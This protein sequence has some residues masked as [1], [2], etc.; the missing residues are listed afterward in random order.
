MGSPK[1]YDTGRKFARGDTRRPMLR[2]SRF[3]IRDTRHASTNASRVAIRD[4][5]FT[6]HDS[7][8]TTREPMIH[9]SAI[10]EPQRGWCGRRNL[11]S[12]TRAPTLC[13]RPNTAIPEPP[14]SDSRAPTLCGR[15]N[16]AIPEPPPSDSRAPTWR[17]RFPSHT[18][19]GSDF[20]HA[21]YSIRSKPTCV[22]APPFS[23]VSF[24]PHQSLWWYWGWPFWRS[25]TAWVWTHTLSDAAPTDSCVTLDVPLRAA[26]LA[27]NLDQVRIVSGQLIM[28]EIGSARA[29]HKQARARRRGRGAGLGCIRLLPPEIN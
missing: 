22:S 7:R 6:I 16:T 2:E 15:P 25:T 26:R 29:G 18:V 1:F 12:D 10:V 14:P 20:C 3:A 11:D 4:S 24:P 9:E 5:R 27:H 28:H 21:L 17:G 13:G 19:R 8:Y 23:R